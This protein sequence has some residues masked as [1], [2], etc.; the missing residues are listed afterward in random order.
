MKPSTRNPTV[1]P[2]EVYRFWAKGPDGSLGKTIEAQETQ[3]TLEGSRVFLGMGSPT[4]LRQSSRTISTVMRVFCHGLRESSNYG[5]PRPP[6]EPPRSASTASAMLYR[7]SHAIFSRAARRPCPRRPGRA[8]PRRRA[9]SW[10]GGWNGG[11]PKRGG[12]KGAL[13]GP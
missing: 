12:K 1:N 8:G 11:W 5:V 3:G 10:S 13:K 7:F 6:V 2:Q 4:K 9:P